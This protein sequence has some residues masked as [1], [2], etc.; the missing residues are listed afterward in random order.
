MTINKAL[1]KLIL[2]GVIIN[3]LLAFIKFIS[4]FIFNSL[5]LIADGVEPLTDIFS[6]I[7]IWGG[8][9]YGEQAPDKKHPLWTWQS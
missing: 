5:A 9:K 7:I 4:G 2:L 6:S 1:V 8:V 3:I